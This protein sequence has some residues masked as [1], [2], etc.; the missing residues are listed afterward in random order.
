MNRGGTGDAEQGI[1]DDGTDHIFRGLRRGCNFSKIRGLARPIRFKPFRRRVRRILRH[2]T[3]GGRNRERG[4]Q[5][6]LS[7]PL[8]ESP[9]SS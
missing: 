1:R 2:R 3:D 6:R 4:L 9:V 8:P 7:D 5:I